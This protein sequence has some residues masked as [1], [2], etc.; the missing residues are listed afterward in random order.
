[1]SLPQH[2]KL[3]L[4]QLAYGF[5]AFSEQANKIG[6]DPQNDVEHFIKKHLLNYDHEQK[7]TFS[8]GKFM[9][10][11]AILDF[12]KLGNILIH[13]DI[14]GITIEK[15]YIHTTLNPL[16]LTTIDKEF[17][18]FINDKEITTFRDFISY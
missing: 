11:L 12:E 4:K 8:K 18:S 7:Y 14:I 10:G 13:L 5:D 15:L 6:H 2:K 17:C 1:M 3:F 16:T 9:M